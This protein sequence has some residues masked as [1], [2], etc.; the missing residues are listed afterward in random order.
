MSN[1]VKGHLQ[2]GD[3]DSSVTGLD[4]YKNSPRG[5]A[6]MRE[7]KPADD[8]RV[9]LHRQAENLIKKVEKESVVDSEKVKIIKAAIA[10]GSYKVDPTA[11]AEKL[12]DMEHELTRGDKIIVP[13]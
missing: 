12:L 13:D 3:S 2:I 11:V 9:S 4:N 7:K 1:L 6:R 8:S 5:I 10:D